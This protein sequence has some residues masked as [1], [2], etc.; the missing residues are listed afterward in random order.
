MRPS[1]NH[2]FASLFA[3]S[4]AEAT[5]AV[6]QCIL[7]KPRSIWRHSPIEWPSS[8]AGSLTGMRG[9]MLYCASPDNLIQRR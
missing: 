8:F 6:A 1:P 2:A 7:L 9:G 3:P 4:L 5:D